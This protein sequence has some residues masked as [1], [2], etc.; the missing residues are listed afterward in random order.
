M[1]QLGG[2]FLF[3]KTIDIDCL[4]KYELNFLRRLYI[5]LEGSLREQL[6]ISLEGPLRE[7]LYISLEGSLREQLYIS[8]EGPLRE[9][10]RLSPAP[11]RTHPTDCVVCSVRERLYAS[12][13]I[14]P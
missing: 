4:T 6:Y 13:S 2:D 14:R 10:S 5:S 11:W 3:C 9:P 1:F 7:Q 12:G 8:L